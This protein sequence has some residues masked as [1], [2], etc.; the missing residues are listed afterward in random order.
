VQKE[1][2][3][4]SNVISKEKLTAYQR[5]EMTSFNDDNESHSKVLPAQTELEKLQIQAKTEA[6]AIGYKEGYEQGFE[7]G[8][9]A[10]FAEIQTRM[11]AEIQESISTI[12]QCGQQFA[13][14]LS[15]AHD[16]IGKDFILL[17]I[18]LAQAMT[19]TQLQLHPES[20]ISI[21]EESIQLLPVIHQPA[22]IFLHPLDAKIIEE[23]LSKKLEQ[24]GW[25]IV[26]D[27]T[28]E[29]GGCRLETA[30]NIIDSTVTTRWERLTDQLKSVQLKN[31][32]ELSDQLK[33]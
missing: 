19:K 7:E 17:A 13:L 32:D 3:L 2:T 30:H 1:K 24:D 33:S 15:K 31:N 5:W 18:D 14:E 6:Y 20:I 8:E 23:N 25:K 22:Q 16:E 28:I 29:R 9:K 4:L 27:N 11:Q 10:G 12:E 26:S 21:V